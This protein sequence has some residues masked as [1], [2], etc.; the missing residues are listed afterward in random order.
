[1]GTYLDHINYFWQKEE[2][3]TF[4]GA[5]SR[6]YFYLC[7][8]INRIKGWD[9]Q[10]PFFCRNNRKT[11]ADLAMSINTIKQARERLR[12][13]GLI[14][15]HLSEES[16]RQTVWIML[17]PEEE[18]CDNTSKIDENTD[19]KKCNT[20]KIDANDDEENDETR[21]K[22]TRSDETRQ[23]THQKLTRTL[24]ETPTSKEKR[25]SK[26]VSKHVKM[27]QHSDVKS[28]DIIKIVDIDKDK[29]KIYKKK[30]PVGVKEKAHS[31]HTEY[32]AF[33][34]WV[35]T[36]ARYC[37]GNMQHPSE[38]E[39]DAMVQEWGE[40][41][42]K[43]EVMALENNVTWREN[44]SLLGFTMRRSLQKDEK[45]GRLKYPKPPKKEDAIVTVRER[46]PKKSAEDKQADEELAKTRYIELLKADAAKGVENA[47]TRLKEMGIEQY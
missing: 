24:T 29:R 28:D 11:E 16:N 42:M 17:C 13:A 18:E 20:S 26:H 31:P 7:H 39:Y 19:D 5:E 45:D 38:S 35:E 4:S 15:F 21:Q 34:D 30:T 23:E 25:V 27:L 44:C 14:D 32:S 47:I 6:L 12:K 8:Q 33:L 40:D 37:F 9:K 1:M 2:E 46:K 43:E 41:N 36:N 10:P 22:M 3:N